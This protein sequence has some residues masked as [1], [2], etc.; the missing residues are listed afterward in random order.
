MSDGASIQGLQE[1]QHANLRRINAMKPGG[2]LGR[3]VQYTTVSAHRYAVS[4][5][6]VWRY[7]GGGL[8]ASHRM[9]VSGLRGEIY[10]DPTAVN[11][12]GQKPSVYGPA[13]HARGGTHAFYART[14]REYGLSSARAGA[15]GLVSEITRK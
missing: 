5:T 9:K 2:A 10:I 15:Y 4:I 7:K 11:P 3:A 8:R 1:A 14:Q 6:H 12:R 13:E